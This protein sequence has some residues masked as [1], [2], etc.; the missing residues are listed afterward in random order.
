MQRDHAF[1][2]ICIECMRI[3]D[4]LSYLRAF[5]HSL[6]VPSHRWPGVQ[7]TGTGRDERKYRGWHQTT[8]LSELQ[9]SQ[10]SERVSGYKRWI[11]PAAQMLLCRGFITCPEGGDVCEKRR[12]P[13]HPTTTPLSGGETWGGRGHEWQKEGGVPKLHPRAK[14]ILQ[15]GTFIQEI[16]FLAYYG[17]GP[18]WVL[19]NVLKMN[20]ISCHLRCTKNL[21]RE[22]R[23][24]HRWSQCKA[25]SDLSHTK[26]L[27]EFSVEERKPL[28]KLSCH[29]SKPD[30]WWPSSPLS[31]L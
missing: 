25:S 17:W 13:P 7:G 9:G 29:D 23:T 12:P 5:H 14:M 18:V 30:I 2:P 22:A 4:N 8:E 31:S 3:A 24:V 6:P 1:S 19:L 15:H 21:V 27:G 26:H 11:L 20:H 10:S 16:S 28:G